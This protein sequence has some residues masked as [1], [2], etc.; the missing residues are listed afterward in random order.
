[1][2]RKP[3]L[4]PAD[5]ATESVPLAY[6]QEGLWF[7]QQ[8][9]AANTAYTV[10]LSLRLAP[11]VSRTSFEAALTALVGRHDAL[12]LR[13]E[14]EG[15]G[16]PTLRTGPGY[17][18]ELRWHETAD[19]DRWHELV[20]EI[21]REPFDLASGRL[22]RGVGAL[23][24]GG[25][26]RVCLAIPHI[27]A[28]GWS[29]RLISRDLAALHAGAELPPL[30]VTFA[31]FAAWQRGW[32]RGETLDAEL[33]YWRDE[34]ATSTPLVLP[35]DFAA[36]PMT[37]ATAAVATM[38][39]PADVTADLL[40]VA[41]SARA[42]GF[43]ATTAL[44]AALLARWTSE[45]DLLLGTA[46]AGRTM[47]ALTDVVGNFV[48]TVALRVDLTDDPSF[49]DLLGRVRGKVLQAMR[50]SDAPF[51]HVVA[52]LAPRRDLHRQPVF[53]VVI[54]HQE[55]TGAAADDDAAIRLEPQETAAVVA[56]HFDLDAE[57]AV[58]DG[59]LSCLLIY[60]ADLFAAPTIERLRDHLVVLARQVAR[61]PD[62][63]LFDL[64]LTGEPTATPP[65]GPPPAAPLSA[66]PPPDQEVALLAA[67]AEHARQ[68]P[69]TD[70]VA[71]GSE[72]LT[73][74]ELLHAADRKAAGLRRAGVGRGDI[75]AVSGP[76]RPETI[77]DAL[78]VLRCGAAYTLAE[79]GDP[80]M[81]GV[82]YQAAEVAP[83][84]A[85]FD[86]D[87]PTPQDVAVLQHTPD[88]PVLVSYRNLAGVSAGLDPVPDEPVL[89]LDG[90]PLALWAVLRAG[91]TCV[92]PDGGDVVGEVSRHAP[93]TVLLT[94]EQLADVLDADPA[95]LDPVDAVVVAGDPVA[96]A[97]LPVPRPVRRTHGRA[98]TTGV[99][100]AYTGPAG[101][102][103]TI[104]APVDG[105]TAYVLDD[106]MR[107]VPPGMVG[108]LHIGG[109]GVTAGYHGRA[110]L[111]AER[112]RP[113]PFGPPGARLFDTGDRAFVD[114]DG[115]LRWFDRRDRRVTVGGTPVD[116]AA[117]EGVLAA[118]PRVRRAAVVSHRSG[119]RTRLAAFIDTAPEQL[120]GVLAGAARELGGAALPEHAEV[121][122]DLPAQ[123]DHAALLARLR[124]ADASPD[125]ERVAGYERL[126]SSVWRQVLDT[127]TFTTTD[128]FFDVGG[129]SLLALP[130]LRGVRDATGITLP[131][132]SLFDFPTVRDLARHLADT[133]DGPPPLRRPDVDRD[134]PAPLTHGQEALWILD[135]MGEARHAFNV[136]M[137]V[138]L[139]A[140]ADRDRVENAVATLIRRHE[141]LRTRYEA[142]PDGHPYQVVIAPYPPGLVW[143]DL[144]DLTDDAARRRTAEL[145][146]AVYTESF[147]L[148]RGEVLRGIV[149]VDRA[150]CTVLLVCHHIAVDAWSRAVLT[151]ELRAAYEGEVLPE[152]AAQMADVAHWQ[153]RQLTGEVLDQ[154]L[155]YWRER[156]AGAPPLELP[157]GGRRASGRPSA[158][159]EMVTARW[160]PEVTAGLLRLAAAEQVSPYATVA[161]LLAACLVP[162]TTGGDVVFGSSLTGRLL[163]EM[164]DLVGLLTNTVMLRADATDDPSFRTLLRR[165]RTETMTAQQHQDTPYE[166]VVPAMG[167][168]SDGGRNPLS[169]VLL[170]Y[171]AHSGDELAA[172][173]DRPGD[174]PPMAV[175]PRFGVEVH[176]TLLDDTLALVVIFRSAS[177]D[178]ADMRALLDR[179]GALA[180]AV[181]HQPDKPLSDVRPADRPE[182]RLS[183]GPTEHVPF[184][185][186]VAMIDEQ[187]ARRPDA[188]AV[189]DESGHLSYAELV[190][191]ANRYARH[192]RATGIR[193]GDVVAVCRR[194]DVDRVV[195]LLGILKAG[196]AYLPLDPTHPPRRIQHA[197]D[198]ARPVLLVAD[199]LGAHLGTERVP[200]RDYDPDD[201][202]VAGQPATPP[203]VELGPDD[204][205]NV[206]FTSGSTG[207]P[208]GVAVPHGA[209]A[210]FFHGSRHWLALEP[211]DRMLQLAPHTFDVA[212]LELLAPLC[213]GAATVSAPVD[214]L[215]DDLGT[216]VR[217]YQ[218]TVVFLVPPLL[219]LAID[220]GV[221]ELAPLRRIV[222]GGDVIATSSFNTLHCGQPPRR[223]MPVYGPT[224]TSVIA[225]VLTGDDLDD[226]ELTGPVPIGRPVANVHWYVLDSR[227]RPVPRGTRGEIF[228][229]GAGVARG[230]L[231]RPDLTADRFL[232]DPFGPPG[233]RMY[234]TGDL[235]R[236]RPDGV[237]EF[238]GRADTQVKIR[239]YR[240]ELEEIEH[241]MRAHPSVRFAAAKVHRA[242]TGPVLVGY[243]VPEEGTAATESEEI[244]RHLADLLPPYAVPAVVE[245]VPAL[246]LSIHGKLDRDALPD[247]RIEAA[248]DSGPPRTSLEG[249]VAQVWSAVLGRRIGVHDDFF[250]AGG[251]SLL[252]VHATDRLRADLGWEVPLRL[253]FDHPSV[254]RYAAAL[255]RLRHAGDRPTGVV[256]RRQWRSE[257]LG[258]NRRVDL[259]VPAGFT[260]SDTDTLLVAPDGSDF[261][262]VMRAPGV[263]DDLVHTGRIPPTPALFVAHPDWS[264]RQA[265]LSEG[266]AFVDALMA[267]AVPLACEWLGLDP[268]RIRVVAAGASLGAVAAVTAAVRHPLTVDGVVAL[269]GPLWWSPAGEEPG[270]LLRQAD[271]AHGTRFH[272]YAAEGDDPRIR[273]W[274]VRLADELT[275][276]GNPVRYV[277]GPG[278]HTF[279]TW[280]DHLPDALTWVL[281]ADARQPAEGVQGAGRL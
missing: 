274:S 189:V 183:A 169:D 67:I 232:P 24:P 113:D 272:V 250:A 124:R 168:Q 249:E 71:T 92:L 266:V 161:S 231:G 46:M 252:V 50:H 120:T 15:N 70:A 7:L 167:G 281:S 55:F 89:L 129:H 279:A 81:P 107:P 146:A 17:T 106:R 205:A 208:K 49:R 254:A 227:F 90:F 134:A 154:K 147:D 269:S 246:P 19:D 244:R 86:G 130:V 94:A 76:V 201:P 153:R 248:P 199:D 142:G 210:N 60:R 280:Q 213:A 74:A 207:T 163:A 233:S 170:V 96:L 69:D 42:T 268:D 214:V 33:A 155:R 181:V 59:R 140:D 265:E 4:L 197:L 277:A 212:T 57:T 93:S 41:R 53:N 97:E 121:T 2:T 83:A 171:T 270:W 99:A 104:G 202:A 122:P 143:H 203:E 157:T 187:A 242:E 29:V 115:N 137:S 43:V 61:D 66:G 73:Y 75:V 230:Y 47:A 165:M 101:E 3:P 238:G 218:A 258:T 236:Q 48:N 117:V 209:L 263:L 11:Q 119:G 103:R 126:V 111:T 88:G 37:T 247:P 206:L 9:D 105:A 245:T 72:S 260:P 176:T 192:L 215:A 177:Y 150:A 182:P 221:A 51:H 84:D 229:G 25:G 77:V 191:R 234:R 211:G 136:P 216:L 224:E 131:L 135:R 116:P 138:R 235:G 63:P 27:V 152:P 78:A 20:A 62:T 278:G 125:P 31:D 6:S 36:G 178:T 45:R 200:V 194:R 151:R 26:H 264:T 82:T 159:A 58:V 5:P 118:D 34:L 110:A 180:A 243:Y 141:S 164:T 85:D 173:L 273:A 186:P 132:A 68:R 40:A 228:I 276:A 179:M 28:D 18:P 223:L 188:V 156:L 253:L 225:S 271:A 267:E 87:W 198:Q 190:T 257:L 275:A 108:R 91:G 13:F 127:D 16:A 220:R 219:D 149:V 65:A 185:S 14:S 259:Y 184:H 128:S 54:A 256:H 175:G 240:I 32:L 79:P 226:R 10:P 148:A 109:T 44:V 162:Y 56:S 95:A 222:S 39:L 237:M 145:F 217:R 133:D 35:T 241:A 8:L 251:H 195:V 112:Y 196:A 174:E 98:E 1:M 166:L 239:G 172:A 193:R 261:V 21:M 262:D 80:P 160:E 22:V 123:P 144:R 64:P 204:L 139:A 23:A 255:D 114:T 52:D 30:P 38:T 12:R 100:T 102:P 158:P